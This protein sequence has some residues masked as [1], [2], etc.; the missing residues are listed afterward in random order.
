MRARNRLSRSHVLR[1]QPGCG[2]EPGR[3][4]QRADEGEPLRLALARAS[5]QEVAVLRDIAP[6]SGRPRKPREIALRNL[7]E[8]VRLPGV[9][10]RHEMAREALYQPVG[11]KRI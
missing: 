6:Y 4:A 11:N 3:P 7:R 10:C 1:D 2:I 8:P 9:D 5:H